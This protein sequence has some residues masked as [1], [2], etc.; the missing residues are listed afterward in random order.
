MT[1][2]RRIR[3]W[4][5]GLLPGLLAA[6]AAVACGAPEA[7]PPAAPEATAQPPAGPGAIAPHLVTDGDDLLLSWLEPSWRLVA[8]R[9][10]DGAWSEPAV[11][12]EGTDFFANWADVPK[13][14][15]AGDG[16][17]WA[18]WLAKLGEETYAYGIFLAR[19]TDGGVTWQPRG[20]LHDDGTP[21]EHGFVAWTAE[22]DGL[23]AVWLDGR[24]MLDGGPMALRTAPVGETV[25]TAEV[26]DAR[27][28]ECCP[29]ELV[30]AAGSPIAFYRDRSRE[31]VRDIGVTRRTPAGWTAP[32]TLHDDGWTIPGCPVNGPAA[33]AR[34]R[35]VAAAWFTAA[36]Q[37]PRVQVAFSTDAGASFG[38]PVVVDDG[39]PLG[40]VD[41]ALAAGGGAWVSWL[42]AAGDG[43]QLR[44]ARVDGSGILESR[45]VATT[46]ASRASGIPRLA[47]AGAEL[48]VAW[49]ETAAGEGVSTIRVARLEG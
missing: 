21:T 36:D 17:L 16:T 10:H 6:L 1:H 2:P 18:H 30:A 13:L 20:M 45:T 35:E 25:G 31:E 47:R 7:T 33:E 8:S 23:R 41:L 11:I 28:C 5:H 24:A 4:G 44:L 12:A 29:A 14:A 32:A 3:A 15:L 48:F 46:A 22:G 38:A 43:A 27:V 42:A 40:R 19:S 49:V 39:T 34:G 9:L 37:R 26:L